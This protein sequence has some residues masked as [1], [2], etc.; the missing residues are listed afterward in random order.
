MTSIKDQVSGYF[1]QVVGEV[2]GSQQLHESGKREVLG[3]PEEAPAEAITTSAAHSAA[4]PGE[5]VA[6]GPVV[7]KST[8]SA[9]PMMA[10]P[11]PEHRQNQS[12]A[13][14]HI[15]MLSKVDEG[16]GV[17]V[18]MAS[19]DDVVYVAVPHGTTIQDA[20]NVV[21][22]M[23]KRLTAEPEERDP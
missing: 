11:D 6:A 10:L 3:L 16:H 9:T 4:Q 21:S 19:D 5:P 8:A 15:H 14:V 2:V 23:A 20:R 1:K 12:E 17:F 13:T 22:R 18:K 7:P